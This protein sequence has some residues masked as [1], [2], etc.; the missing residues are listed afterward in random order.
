MI[1]TY[2]RRLETDIEDK[3]ST[4]KNASNQKYTNFIVSGDFHLNSFFYFISV[5]VKKHYNCNKCSY[6]IGEI[7]AAKRKVNQQFD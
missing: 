3:L 6:F 4:F 2:Q 5:G 1:S 7:Q